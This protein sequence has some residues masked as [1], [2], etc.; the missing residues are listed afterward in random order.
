MLPELYELSEK[1]FRLIT[2]ISD[3]NICV[4]HGRINL[5][6]EDIQI[7]ERICQKNWKYFCRHNELFDL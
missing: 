1:L 6:V 7:C 3:Y 2:Q 4:T 5:R